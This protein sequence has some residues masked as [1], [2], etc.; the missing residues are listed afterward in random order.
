MFD[1]ALTED[2]NH[3]ARRPILEEMIRQ[4]PDTGELLRGDLSS[5][6]RNELPEFLLK[7]LDILGVKL[8]R[9]LGYKVE[10]I[11]SYSPHQHGGIPKEQR[12]VRHVFY[13]ADGTVVKV[14]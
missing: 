14:V 7:A 12:K 4:V 5:I 13:L 11:Y 1:P 3:I 10:S 6:L 8:I 9:A 2:I